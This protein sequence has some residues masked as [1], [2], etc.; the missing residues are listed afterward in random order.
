MTDESLENL[1]SAVR[2]VLAEAETRVGYDPS[3]ILAN[4]LFDLGNA[5]YYYEEAV[6]H[7]R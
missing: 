4:T 7:A 6:G 1:I 5:L 2:R 3:K